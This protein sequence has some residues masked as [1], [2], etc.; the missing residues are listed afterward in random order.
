M[1]DVTFLIAAYNRRDVL[2]DTLRQLRRCGLPAGTFETI[3]VDNAS[4]DGTTGAVAAAFPDVILIR[5]KVNRGAC[6][7]N[8]GLPLARGRYIVFLDDDS[9]PLPGSVARMI[10]HFE[11]DPTLGA[12]V[13]DVQLPDGSRECSAYPNVFIGCGTGFRRRA[14]AEVGGL[15]EDFFMQAE[16]YDLSLRLL[17]DGWDVRRFDDLHVA[18]LKTSTARISTRTTRL[19]VRNN[20]TLIG[21][22][23]PDRWV[24]PFALDWANRYAMLAAARGHQLAHWQGV[25]EASIRAVRGI[26]RRPLSD[27]AFEKFAC[28]DEIAGRLRAARDAMGLRTI[29]LADLGKNAFAYWLAAES[30]GLKV[31]AVSDDNLGGRGWTYRGVPIVTNGEARRAPFDAVVVSNMSPVHAALRRDWWRRAQREP[32]ID[33]FESAISA[34]RPAASESRRTVARSA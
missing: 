8:A 24:M 5:E 15:P 21:R 33:L 7:K 23:F 31:V 16:E 11:A 2:L 13:F 18:H 32:V 6:A 14:L 22:Y 27:E 4:T 30:C 12:A 26:E 25:A 1:I 19:D 29:L 28:I 34:A 3:L 17:A 20:L 10:R 9:H